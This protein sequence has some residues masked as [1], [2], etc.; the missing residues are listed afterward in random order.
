MTGRIVLGFD[1]SAGSAKATEYA[2]D[3]AEAS[4]ARLTIVVARPQWVDLPNVVGLMKEQFGPA[5]DVLR[6]KAAARGIEAE[7]RL[8]AGFPAVELAKC[9]ARN[10]AKLVV[11][12]S[13]RRPLWPRW[14]SRSISERTAQ[15]SHC[16][17]V[18][19]A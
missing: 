12:G 9:A 14:I 3:L 11:L 19:V 13:R 8:I 7:I 5:L 6:Q 1:G 15:L 10:G 16:A 17:V 4:G 2:L 18:V